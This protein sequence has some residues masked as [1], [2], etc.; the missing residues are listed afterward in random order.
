MLQLT[1]QDPEALRSGRSDS[2]ARGFQTRPSGSS[3]AGASATSTTLYTRTC[4]GFLTY[5]KPADIPL[6][7]ALLAWRLLVARS[8]EE[9]GVEALRLGRYV[10][11]WTSHRDSPT[12]R[13]DGGAQTFTAQVAKFMVAPGATIQEAH[14]EAERLVQGT[15]G[16]ADE[17]VGANSTVYFTDA[18]QSDGRKGAVSQIAVSGSITRPSQPLVRSRCCLG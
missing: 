18:A 16:R 5:C 13:S 4:D 7:A 6:S 2:A 9:D 3:S 15:L 1:P 14:A 10:E 17:R 11:D 12:T 8:G